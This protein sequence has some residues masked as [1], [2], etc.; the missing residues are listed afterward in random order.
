LTDKQFKTLS[1]SFLKSV[2]LGRDVFTKST[3]SEIT[4]FQTFLK[5]SY[6]Y[7]IVIDGLNVAYSTGTTGKFS[8]QIQSRAVSIL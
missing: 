8:S 3:P 5:Q 6:P 4:A 7:D 1:E 2:V